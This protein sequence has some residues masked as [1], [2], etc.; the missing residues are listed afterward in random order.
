MITTI[1][2]KANQEKPWWVGLLIRCKDCG[3]TGILEISDKDE[4]EKRIMK[5]D[6]FSYVSVA[7]GEVTLI[8]PTCQSTMST[9]Y[10]DS[11]NLSL[12]KM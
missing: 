5:K 4:V 6:G 8:C 3:H 7:E 2:G 12:P 9:D 11:T 1:K 10:A